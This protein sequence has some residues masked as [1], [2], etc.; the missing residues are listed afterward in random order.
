ME[1]K[2]KNLSSLESENDVL[3]SKLKPYKPELE[4]YRPRF[5]DVS[6]QEAP[7]SRLDFLGQWLFLLPLYTYL[8]LVFWGFLEWGLY[9][10]YVYG[11]FCFSFFVFIVF[12]L[13]IMVYILGANRR[14]REKEYILIQYDLYKKN[15]KLEQEKIERNTEMLRKYLAQGR[16]K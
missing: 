7:I 8:G 6:N 3:N 9:S 16:D 2:W 5:K 1:D 14:I 15:R 11:W 4:I 12:I 13:L 10:P